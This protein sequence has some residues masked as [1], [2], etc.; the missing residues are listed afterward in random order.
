[1]DRYQDIL[2]GAPR[3]TT[4]VRVRRRRADR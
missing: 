4:Q 3:G 1:L 2:T